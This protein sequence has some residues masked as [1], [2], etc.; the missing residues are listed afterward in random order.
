MCIR[1]RTNIDTEIQIFCQL[2]IVNKYTI[3]TGKINSA[4]ERPNQPVLK[5]L[6]LDFIKYLEIVVLAVWDII[7]WPENLIRNIPT[8]KN[9][10]DDILE[11]KKHE[12]ERSNV[13]KKANLKMLISSIYFPTHI[14][15]KLLS[16]VAVA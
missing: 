4:V 3:K 11:K 7:P 2:V 12:K 10:T 8:N 9:A 5:A 6:P 1:D 16:N 14:K 15:R 13:T